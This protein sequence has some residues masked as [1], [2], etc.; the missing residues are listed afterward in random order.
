MRY[1][2]RIRNVCAHPSTGLVSSGQLIKAIRVIR[3]GLD[4]FRP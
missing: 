2:R 4:S 3:H 1:A